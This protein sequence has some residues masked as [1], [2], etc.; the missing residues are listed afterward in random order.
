MLCSQG[1]VLTHNV[2]ITKVEISRRGEHLPGKHFLFWA[3]PSYTI[4]RTGHN[5]IKD[6]MCG[7]EKLN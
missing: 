2:E 6:K 3:I 1:E 5:H 4:H 7:S